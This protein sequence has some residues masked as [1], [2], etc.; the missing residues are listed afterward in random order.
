MNLS[1]IHDLLRLIRTGL[2]AEGKCKGTVSPW[3]L[4]GNQ[5]HTTVV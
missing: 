5:F 4:Q 2:R 3:I 1:S